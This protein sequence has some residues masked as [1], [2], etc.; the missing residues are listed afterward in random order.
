LAI[1]RVRQKE[2][3]PPQS[4]AEAV[5]RL[6]DRR[7]SLVRAAYHIIASDGFEKLRTRDVADRVGI[8]I[9]T[10]HY[11]FPSKELLIGE[12]ALFLAA[13]FQTVRAPE[14]LMPPMNALDRLRQE[15][16][17]AR[18][19]MAERPEMMEVMRELNAR[20]RR[21]EVIARIIEPLKHFWRSTIE[22]IVSDG[23]E[24][25][26]FLVGVTPREAAGVIVAMLW[27]A[28]TF[29]LNA[30]ERENVY[31]AIERWLTVPNIERPGSKP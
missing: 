12:V 7:L 22:Q 5:A 15:F 31:G 25:G 24:E 4:P 8:N 29:P 16:A 26:F 20:A 1:L 14:S 17:D 19:Y 11:Y 27:G 3:A 30:G 6:D 28:A 18:F 2:P 23:I 21:D 13:Q 10:L 9:A